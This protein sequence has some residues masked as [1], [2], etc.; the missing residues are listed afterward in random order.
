MTSPLLHLDQAHVWH[1]F[2]QA[3]LSPSPIPIIKAEGLYLYDENGKTYMDLMSSWWVMIH[4]HSHPVLAEA[5]AE[6]ARTLAHVMFANFTHKP[7]VDLAQAITSRL[8]SLFTRVFFSDNGSNAV[9]IALKMAHQYFY[10]QGDR[11]RNRFVALEGGYHGD[12]FGA[13]SVGKTSG[14]YTPFHHFLFQVDFFPYPETWMDDTQIDEKEAA[15]L[16]HSEAFFK[17]H[18]QE[19]IALIM[20]PFMQGASGMRLCRP[21][22]I[23]ALMEQAQAHGV[24]II[25]DEVMTGFGRTGTLFAAEQ[26]PSPPDFI[27]L[28]KGLT[29]GIL[30]LALTVCTDEIYNAFASI[31]SA[32][33][34]LHGHTFTAN[35]IGCAAA[36]AS[37]ALFEEQHYLEKI[38]DMEQIHREG[39]DKIRQYSFV[40]HPRVCGAIAAWTF[41]DP[42]IPAAFT[43]ACLQRGLFLRPLGTS[44]YLMPP[45]I[46]TPEQLTTVYNDLCAIL[47]D[48]SKTLSGLDTETNTETNTDTTCSP[49][50]LF[51]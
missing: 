24:L 17:A 11:T 43:A 13:M 23:N 2:H 46:I 41:T 1:P 14:Y 44:A 5:I 3:K 42:R 50:D 39:L 27:C 9:E 33:T 31:Q 18:G 28:S 49:P 21:S 12:T 26:L 15:A 47:D 45:Y 19:T 6:Q 36:L 20:E 4:G 51:I 34:F 37:L 25:F 29:G 38:K 10:N 48:L 30:P 16:A 7:A 40:K 22:F 35:P 32:K 8:P